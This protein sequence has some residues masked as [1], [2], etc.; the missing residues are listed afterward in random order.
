M[1]SESVENS[2]ELLK[3][4]TEKMNSISVDLNDKSDR[5]HGEDGI[6]VQLRKSIQVSKQ[7]GLLRYFLMMFEMIHQL[8]L[9]QGIA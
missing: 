5:N 9:V 7:I 6:M 4:S 2:S 3:H 8:S 1:I